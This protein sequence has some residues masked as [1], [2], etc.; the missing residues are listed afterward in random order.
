MNRRHFLRVGGSFAALLPSMVYAG[1]ADEAYGAG[2]IIEIAMGGRNNGAHVWFDPTG[3]LIRPGQTIRWTNY[4]KA[5][6]H[7]ATA[8]HPDNFD[9]VRRIPANAAPW[10]SDYLLPGDSFAVTLHEPGVYDYFC[11]PH[12]HAGMVGRIIVGTPEN[13]PWINNE[14]AAHRDDLPDIARRNFPSVDDI[15]ARHVVRPLSAGR[16]D[17]GY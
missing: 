8:Y 4:D 2:G 11:A 7:T 16:P 14:P 17:K 5:N 6:A 1:R 15:M 13:S 3:I 12:E 10:D 9:R